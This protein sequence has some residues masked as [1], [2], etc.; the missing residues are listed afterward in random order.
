MAKIND[1][2]KPL[3]RVGVDPT[4]FND[5]QELNKTFKTLQTALNSY[6]EGH[7]LKVQIDART[8]EGFESVVKN[9]KTQLEGIEKEISIR[10]HNEQLKQTLDVA[11]AEIENI[12]NISSIPIRV[13]SSQFSA[14][15]ETL[16]SDFNAQFQRIAG[17]EALGPFRAA[18]R[19]ISQAAHVV[20][21]NT[22]T[23]DS[24]ISKI[25]RTIQNIDLNAKEGSRAVSGLSGGINKFKTS[26]D[27]I[28][29]AE[30]FDQMSQGAEN[31]GRIIQQVVDKINLFKNNKE[32]RSAFQLAFELDTEQTAAN[33]ARQMSVVS[34]LLSTAHPDK[35]V[36]LIGTLDTAKTAEQIRKVIPTVL[37]SELKSS[38]LSTDIGDGVLTA[39]NQ[40][41]SKASAKNNSAKTVATS[42]EIV[43]VKEE[44]ASSTALID[45][46]K[47]HWDAAF[48]SLTTIQA[49]EQVVR[50]NNSLNQTKT[51][52][53][54][55][56]RSNSKS[57]A[58]NLLSQDNF[59]LSNISSATV[60][61]QLKT[62]I[63]EAI[64]SLNASAS[65]LNAIRLRFDASA[66]K[67]EIEKVSKDVTLSTNA[68]VGAA[69]EQ[70]ANAG[71]ADSGV[72]KK[73]NK[74]STLTSGDV[75]QQI[76]KIDAALQKAKST[77]DSFDVNAMMDLAI[78]DKY[79][80]GY[81]NLR[82]KVNELTAA[83]KQL[84]AAFSS[85][86]MQSA[87][88]FLKTFDVKDKINA[89]KGATTLGAESK[90]AVD[91]IAERARMLISLRQELN[92]YNET[93]ARSAFTEKHYRKSAH[94]IDK[95]DYSYN[96]EVNKLKKQWEE[97]SSLGDDAL[98]K[99]AGEVEALK[100]AINSL[101]ASLRTLKTT[102]EA[103]AG[104]QTYGITDEFIAKSERQLSGLKAKLEQMRTWALDSGFQILDEETLNAQ[105]AQIDSALTKL[106]RAKTEL[107]AGAGIS[108]E[109]KNI[110]E[111]VDGVNAG[112]T[113]F[114]D[115][116][117][118]ARAPVVA[119]R[120]ELNKLQQEQAR[121]NDY[122]AKYGNRL[123]RY[124]LLWKE[125][126][127]VQER[128]GYRTIDSTEAKESIDEVM[129]RARAAGVETET[130]F[131]KIW[132]RVGFNFR[133]MVASMGLMYVWT[134]FRDIYE[135]VK[136]LDA[137]MTELKK[138]TEGTE[139]TYL[140]FLDNAS[141]RAQR[142]GASL[143]DVVSATS[144]FARL[145]YGIKDASTL[146]D[147]ATIYLNV[148]DD[149]ENIDQA[150]KSIISTM[151]GFGIET[152]KVMNIVDE[153]N[154]VSNKYASSAGDIGEITQRSA[155]AMRAAG[156]S[157]EETI[158]LG[159][160]ANTVAQDADTVGTA[161][162]TM[163]MRL[164]STETEMAAAGEDTEGMAESVSKLR[165]EIL[166]LSG[167][168]IML[169]EETYKTPYQMLIEIGKVW[170]NL[171]DLT[172]ANITELLFGK[173]QANIGSA[174]LQNV[175]LAESILKDAGNSE[176]SA[177]KEN[178][179]YLESIN[180][181]LAKLQATWE[182]FSNDILGSE[183]VK[184]AVDFLN[185]IFKVLNA[186]VENL[187]V[188]P[189]L[190]GAI[191]SATLASSNTGKNMPPYREFRQTLGCWRPSNRQC[192]ISKSWEQLKL[193]G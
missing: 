68:L 108:S 106:Q 158:A 15:V 26:L 111:T 128:I 56:K 39:L 150:T 125:I 71:T 95:N 102:A 183:L 118:Q 43:K 120:K 163:S 151:Q 134:A 29:G 136:E 88:A 157:L 18:M 131:T 61:E 32:N 116:M 152:S 104:P 100:Q 188:I 25:N 36:K 149:V 177:L 153:F 66:L 19:E 107:G 59:N 96:E 74:K 145:G 42:G 94:Y 10:I 20:K 13:D 170:D 175:E 142:L 80:T 133:S 24:E 41:K 123:K 160:T 52:L 109:F 181:K 103:N 33:I 117:K 21:S 86:D 46:L 79:I 115:K 184:G 1:N 92:N 176:N 84:S 50:L 169:D 144:D 138:V 174:I 44:I 6:I 127:K 51:L 113:A 69:V 110:K 3:I 70:A 65:S 112:T 49:Q 87:Q 82:A 119:A 28:S 155:A 186:I 14:A 140:Q 4:S 83:Y 54:G 38:L 17:Q 161:L 146:S 137:A 47:L 76:N 5:T 12:R 27:S 178:E 98:I 156:S 45:G 154:N 60:A 99:K 141:D 11:K 192:E 30:A 179:I 63:N 143:V 31:V 81:E 57:G 64:G 126:E 97:L 171:N 101:E 16:A 48:S 8:T 191:G 122:V 114:V 91:D 164:R 85:N 35:Q 67:A 168:D 72:Q 34:S 189:T 147:A 172:R 55:L 7:P 129:M 53:Q 173:R 162:K 165:N 73:S 185:G 193:A 77:L 139:K 159:V 124:P 2:N 9:V 167:V 78:P 23:L 89:I 105:I 22:A 121:I 62:T 58:F 130:I 90:L 132:D 93:L 40:Q 37:A 187:G 182:V 135:N 166:A 148:G 75:A 190:I 180:G